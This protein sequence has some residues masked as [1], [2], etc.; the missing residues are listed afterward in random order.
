MSLYK[1]NSPMVDPRVGSSW[2]LARQ[3]GESIRVWVA[4]N[5]EL[6]QFFRVVDAL[7]VVFSFIMVEFF[8]YT[9][10]SSYSIDLE[11]AIQTASNFIGTFFTLDY[12]I[13]VYAA[14]LRLEYVRSVFAIVDFI[15]VAS[16]WIE[17]CV[18]NEVMTTLKT[19]L[20]GRQFLSMLQVMKSLRILRAYRLLRFTS[21]IVQ[22]QMLATLLTVVCMIIAVAGALQNLELCPSNCPDVC[23]PLYRNDTMAC[24]DVEIS[25]GPLLNTTCPAFVNYT[26]ANI[27]GVAAAPTNCCRCQVYRFLDWIYFVVVTISTLGYGDI[28]PKTAMG[29]AATA[30]LIMMM[31]VL[32]PIQVNKLVDVISQH[33]RYN[34]AYSGRNDTHGVITAQHL[35]VPT[36]RTFLHQY[37]HPQNRN[38][39]ERIIVLYA[40]EPSPDMTKLIHAYEPRVTYIVGSAMQETDLR[41]AAVPTSAVCYIL[42]SQYDKSDRADQMCSILTT[43]FRVMNPTVPIF[44]QVIRSTSV[45]Y[46]T[47]SGASNVVCVQKLKMSLLALSCGAVQKIFRVA[48]PRSFSGLT[49]LELVMFLFNNLQVI[50]IAM[51]VADSIQLNPMDFKLGQAADPTLCCTVYVI[52]PSLEVVDRI[53]EYPLEQIRVFRQTLRKME[54]HRENASTGVSPEKAKSKG[55]GHPLRH[56]KRTLGGHLY[57]STVKMNLDDPTLDSGKA[58]DLFMEKEVPPV[59]ERHIVIVGLPFSLQDLIEPLRNKGESHVVVILSPVKLSRADFES[60]DHRDHTYFALG[61]PLSS[62]DLQRVSITSASSVIVLS[63]VAGKENFFDENMVDAN[64]ITCVRFIIEASNLRHRHPPNLVVELARHTNVRFLSLI[65]KTES[66]RERRLSDHFNDF[67]QEYEDDLL[68]QDDDDDVQIAHICEPAYASGRVC[69]NGLVEALM[70]ECYR[71]PNLPSIIDAMLHGQDSEYDKLQL[72]QVPC[73]KALVGKSFGESFRRLLRLNYICIGCWH[74]DNGHAGPKATPAYVHTNPKPETELHAK[75]LL[76]IVGKPTS[77]ID[78]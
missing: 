66:R 49:Y 60:L 73:P 78:I 30:T 55:H 1:A 15:G 57:S 38:W 47:M 61:S 39:N 42:T 46:C 62:F 36:L 26:L 10:W 5:L 11:P 63:S 13:R 33:S 65:V 44:T 20:T 27:T 64:A 3:P 6:S 34:K 68:G 19:D 8:L 29:R 43:A 4:R 17:I 18:T 50:T 59:L 14:P 16:A 24:S 45:S 40:Q 37:F 41:R 23:I 22:R 76:Y 35:D 51:E 21:S 74:T 72:F 9:N 58:Y 70:S 52:A 32:V 12:V 56:K 31:F 69:V 48:I 7:M 53:A 71:S 54:R 28:S 67:I 2:I 77:T 75:D 25:F